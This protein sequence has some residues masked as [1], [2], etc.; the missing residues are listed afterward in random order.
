MEATGGSQTLPSSSPPCPCLHPAPN[1]PT[2]T[3]RPNASIVVG[4]RYSTLATLSPAVQTYRWW[5]RAFWIWPSSCAPC[6]K[7]VFGGLQNAEHRSTAL[8][9][10]WGSSVS[11]P[12]DLISC[13]FQHLQGFWEWSPHTCQGTIVNT[14]GL[15]CKT[16]HMFTL[17]KLLC[18]LTF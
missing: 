4:V 6:V 14:L 17:Y 16:L 11:Q 8:I 1:G 2:T 9:A 10:F 5:L 3:C 15:Q 7:R 13:R 18:C 12:M